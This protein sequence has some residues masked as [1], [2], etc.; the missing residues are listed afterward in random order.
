MTFSSHGRVA[1]ASIYNAHTSSRKYAGIIYTHASIHACATSCR[2]T[3]R[4][5]EG[6][7]NKK[8][9]SLVVMI[10][11]I[12]IGSNITLHSTVYGTVYG[13]V[14][15]TLYD[16]V[17]GTVYDIRY[18]IRLPDCL[19][20]TPPREYKRDEGPMRSAHSVVQ[21]YQDERDRMTRLTYKNRSI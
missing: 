16:T 10:Y 18:G 21:I 4:V 2:Y 17:Y 14:Y 9:G 5:G 12:S 13:T 7:A 20:V 3:C 8:D 1:A 15:S 6:T 19:N 11:S